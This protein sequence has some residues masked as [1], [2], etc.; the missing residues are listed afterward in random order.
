MSKITIMQTKKLKFICL[1][2]LIISMTTYGQHIVRGKVI[3]GEDNLPLPGVSVIVQGSTKGTITDIS[4]NYT[5]ETSETATLNFSFV[6]FQN[7]NEAVRNRSEINITLYQDNVIMDEVIVM[8]YSSLKR[9]ELSSSIVS[10]DSEQLTDVKTHDLGN[11]LQGKVAGLTISV[12][13]GQPGT[14]AEMRIRGTGSI[15]ALS[16]PLFVV[17]GIPGGSYNPNDVETVTVLKDAGATAIYGADGAGGVIVITTKHAAKNQAT[18][19]NLKASYGLKNALHGNFEMMNG[20]ELYDTHKTIYSPT[21][22][23]AQ[24]PAALRDMNYDW[25]N[26]S[27]RTGHVQ[28]YYLSTTGAT[29]RMR[30]FT[31]LDYYQDE[32]TLINTNYERATARVNLSTNLYDNLELNIR[33]SYNT[34]NNREPSSYIVLEG[35]YRTIPWD[36]PFD[37]EGNY[38]MIDDDI[39]PDNG[40]KWYTQDRRN[41]LHGEQYNYAKS[42]SQ[43]LTA[44]IQLNWTINDWLMFTTTNRYSTSNYK[45]R[46]FIDPRTYDPSWANGYTQNDIGMYSSIGT[47]NLLKANKDFGVHSVSG[48][49]GYEYGQ[50]FSD[51]TSAAGVGMPNGIDGLTAS[52]PQDVS[53]YYYE[54]NGYSW[55]LQAQYS[56]LSKYFL[57]ASFRADASS[58]FSKNHPVGYFPGGAASWLISNEDFLKD[59]DLITFLKLR[60]SYGVTGNS[61]IDAF[62]SLAMYALSTSYQDNVGAVL[63]RE[64][65]PNLTWETAHMSGIGLDIE[66]SKRVSLNIDAYNIDNKNLLLNVPREPSSGFEYGLENIGQVN[67][68]GLELQ[69]SSDNI[70]NSKFLW[71]TTFNIGFNKNE[72]VSMPDN[73]PLTF[74]AGSSSVT[75]E[76]RVGQDINSWYL[77]KWVGVDPDNGDPLWEKLIRDTEGNIVDQG[78]TTNDYNQAGAQVVGKAT[79]LFSGGFSNTLKYQGFGLYFAGNY[80]Y[81]NTI[82]NRDRESY[83]ADGA[84]LGYNMMRLHKGWSRWEQPGDIATHPRPAMNGNKHSNSTSSRYLE[85]G[86]FL[87]LKNVTFSYDLPRK[88][89][90]KIGLS[91]AK[92]YL[93]GDNLFTLTNFSGLDPEVSLQNS[94]WSLAGVYSFGY[95][96]SRQFLIGFDINF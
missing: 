8:G 84:Y 12:P 24:R 80:I 53:G 37:D 15:T 28:N 72:V 69:L 87:R 22:F 81:G 92:V 36:I 32:G 47:T 71:N 38:V 48:L 75:Q 27:F 5:I 30:Y 68:K 14:N 70:K 77:P 1:F 83:D 76:V 79:P 64:A 58:K 4:G 20:E 35:A 42:R 66:F 21:L 51:Y 61:K 43:G 56:Y 90:T 39:R 41:F 29:D 57:T 25:L 31:S 85:D 91:S 78:G 82:Y 45:Y 19:V 54:G 17:D 86:S 73:K 89:L 40:K 55:F 7:Q 13:S 65:N 60:A 34:S 67:N 26:S 96:V 23:A 10:I 11:M 6:G 50:H 46:R 3:A 59:N 44:D 9:A 62:Q 88:A 2:F 93:S 74:T 94:Q 33:T 18:Q 16:S 95:P 49:I 52:I 63:E